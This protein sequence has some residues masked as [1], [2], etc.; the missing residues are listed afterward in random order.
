MCTKSSG[1]Q[2]LSYLYSVAVVVFILFYSASGRGGRTP[3]SANVGSRNQ[4]SSNRR[5]S[6]NRAGVTRPAQNFVSFDYTQLDRRR[7]GFI[8]S[9]VST[10][11]FSISNILE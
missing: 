5:G 1:R 11:S 3:E 6:Q 9:A 7:G 2:F 4:V 10:F 8:N